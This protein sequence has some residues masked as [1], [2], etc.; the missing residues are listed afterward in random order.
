M[1]EGYKER[2]KDE[3]RLNRNILFVMQKLWSSKPVND[4]DSLW[5]IDGDDKESEDEIKK[6]FEA[7][8]QKNG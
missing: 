2:R 6:L 5:N 7:V 4:P 8:K 3:Y 1:V